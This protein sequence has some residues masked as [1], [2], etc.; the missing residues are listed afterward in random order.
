MRVALRIDELEELDIAYLVIVDL[1]SPTD[2][3][4]WVAGMDGV[5]RQLGAP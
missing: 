5:L 1:D 4:F 3:R 2:N